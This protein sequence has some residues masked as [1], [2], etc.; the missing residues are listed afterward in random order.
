MTCAAIKEPPEPGLISIPASGDC[1]FCGCLTS[2]LSLFGPGESIGMFVW[3]PA[4]SFHPDQGPARS[5]FI[6]ELHIDAFQILEE[7]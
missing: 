1:L 7:V 2:M 3:L 5:V 6:A 4:Q